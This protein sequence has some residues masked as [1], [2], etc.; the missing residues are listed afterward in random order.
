MTTGG[1]RVS[2]ALGL[3]AAVTPP[4]IY[5]PLGVLVGPVG[6]NL[7]SPAILERLNPI[8]SLALASI[9]VFVGIAIDPRRRDDAALFVAASL[10]AVTTAAVV[11][12][13]VWL[14]STRWA[15]PVDNP[16]ASVPLVCGLCAAASAA[17]VARDAGVGGPDA[18]A[19]IARVADFDDV[20]VITLSAMA[21]APTLRV[22]GIGLGCALLV[23]V[24]GWLLFE[25]AASDAERGVFVIGAMIL[26]GGI[27][28]YAA[29]SPLL[30]GMVAGACWKHLPGRA[31]EII[32][33]DLAKIDRPLVVLLL[34]IAGAT[35]KITMLAV[36]LAVPLLLFRLTGKLLGA[37]VA[38]LALAS[39]PPVADLAAHLLPS[40]IV[41]IALA[42]HFHQR[43]D[44]ELGAAVV[45]I[46]AFTAV[47][48]DVLTPIAL[49][50]LGRVD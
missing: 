13:A 38:R 20:I 23:S 11:T 40:G 33:E 8:V 15:L 2:A 30:V 45:S 50:D 41:A 46:I 18:L 5:I 3:Q 49:A 29:V 22:L 37:S 4:L 6:L 28:D 9:G 19:R 10:Q 36:W 26:L 12:S 17:V 16:V 24:A 7:L 14:L 1:W 39:Q 42:I 44:G 43:V 21:L 34:V 32:R 47:A 31:N 35:L 48:F 25:R 27:A